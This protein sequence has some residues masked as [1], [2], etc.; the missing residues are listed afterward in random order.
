MYLNP[1]DTPEKTSS[2]QPFLSSFFS[3]L[4]RG[5]S[6]NLLSYIQTN[7]TTNLLLCIYGTV[8][9]WWFNP[10]RLD[11]CHAPLWHLGCNLHDVGLGLNMIQNRK[12]RISGE[13]TSQGQRNP[14]GETFQVKS[15]YPACSS[16]PRTWWEGGKG[17]GG[18]AM[19]AAGGGGGGWKVGVL[20]INEALE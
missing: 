3:I 2:A 11:F 7:D 8:P 17:G 6:N 10:D 9:D 20:E 13:K 1:R 19:A 4:V 15:Y 12:S 5:R 18:V 14:T 16:L